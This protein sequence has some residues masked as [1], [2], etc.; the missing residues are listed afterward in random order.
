[1]YGDC[2]WS[3]AKAGKEKQDEGG[4]WGGTVNQISFKIFLY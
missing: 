1:M 3:L 2:T 4:G